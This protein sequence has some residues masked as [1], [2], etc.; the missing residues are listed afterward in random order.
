M[1]YVSLTYFTSVFRGADR[2]VLGSGDYIGVEFEVFALNVNLRE[3][4][5]FD[6]FTTV[7]WVAERG[8]GGLVTT[9]A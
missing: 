5:E 7:L 6:Y 4:R 3:I 8:I 9:L 2:G 1:K